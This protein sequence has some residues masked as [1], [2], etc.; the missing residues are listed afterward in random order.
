M[1]HM[2][3]RI[4]VDGRTARIKG[5]GLMEPLVRRAVLCCAALCWDVLGCAG[6]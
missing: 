4:V 1:L 3:L 2:W 6:M 5:Y